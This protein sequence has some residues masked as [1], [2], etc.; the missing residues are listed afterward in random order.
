M[1]C[2]SSTCISLQSY[3][4]NKANFNNVLGDTFTLCFLS[5]V[6][7]SSPLIKMKRVPK[8]VSRMHVDC[9]ISTHCLDNLFK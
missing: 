1:S 8:I 2:L 9:Y 6:R 3:F 5:G 7:L 4:F